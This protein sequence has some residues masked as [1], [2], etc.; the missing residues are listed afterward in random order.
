[1]FSFRDLVNRSAIQ[2]GPRMAQRR[3]GASSGSG[4]CATGR[5]EG[6]VMAELPASRY[7]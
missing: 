2:P 3:V 4:L 5:D 7:L 6:K 1:M